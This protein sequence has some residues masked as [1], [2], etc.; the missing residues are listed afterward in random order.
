MLPGV[1]DTEDQ[2]PMHRLTFS[3]R[4]YL[5]LV[6]VLA[7]L[8]AVSVFLPQASPLPTQP[9]PEFPAP[10]PVIAV[11]NAGI[12]LVVYGGLGF[13]GLRL[14]GKLGFA[15]LWSPA[16][17]N[18][19]RFITPALIG[20]STG[21][22]FILADTILSQFHSLGPLPHPPFPTSLVASAVAGIGEEIIFRLFFISF[23]VWLLSCV[24]LKRR[25]QSQIF[26]VVAVISA[27]AFA[28]GHLPALMLILNASDISEVPLALIGE[29]VLLNGVLSL[30][31]AHY[32]RKYGI[33]AAVG[34]HFWADVVWHVLWGLF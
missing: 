31:A 20:A 28:F 9:E 18:Q 29:I 21:I 4:I 23:W 33:L 19:Q 7:V 16:V 11:A 12:M 14:A 30:L 10:K 13:L 3:I 26:W 15:D 25:W 27:L 24:V 5:A 2:Q 6:I 32:F 1:D 8:G 17:S 22:F 34:I